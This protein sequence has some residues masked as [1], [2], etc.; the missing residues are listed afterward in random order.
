[1]SIQFPTD[2]DTLTNPA[3]TDKVATVSHSLQHSNA[4]DAIEA[5][6]AKVGKNNSGVTTSHD[7]KLST[8]TGSDK[9]AVQDGNQTLTNKTL[10]SPVLNTPKVGTSINDV[11]GNE[12][13]K[14]PATASAVN[15]I[16]VTNSVTGNDVSVDATGGD[17]NISLK[18][19]A[20]GTGK[21]KL[22]AVELQFPNVDGSNGELLKTDG[23]GVLS[24]V[25]ATTVPNAS[26]TVAG[27]TE[28]AT[29]AQVTAG[30]ATG[31]TGAKL[32]VTPAKLKTFT[33][34]QL[35]Q[36][37]SCAGTNG[38]LSQPPTTY[39]DIEAIIMTDN[40]KINLNIKGLFPQVRL[41]QYDFAS[42]NDITGAVIIGNYIYLLLENR[43]TTPDSYAVYRYD[44]TNI[45]AGGTLMTIAGAK[46][47]V[48][49]NGM[50][51]TSDGTYFY[52]NYEAGNSA[53][54]YVL[55]KYSLLGTTLTYVSSITCGSAGITEFCIKSD[56][57]IYA[58]LASDE[59]D[60]LKFNSSGTLLTTYDEIL[61][62][63]ARF[64]NIANTIYLGDPVL[65]DGIISK[66][67]L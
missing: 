5:L 51:M 33:D 13:I 55:A 26:E 65:H 66:T 61:S 56:G 19:K 30:T 43:S 14:T 12:V 9:V 44:K 57:T 22:G 60:L 41:T 16:T 25:G 7:Y 45:A 32:F 15:E 18:I 37:I 29:D 11:N 52:F 49:V 34:S 3:A 58:K 8:V 2:L 24:W 62:T 20:K 53:N 36:T 35:P 21:V 39:S 31:E 59:N 4:N 28:E 64:H 48:N 40:D 50:M 6:E 38:V 46:T 42:T 10:T 63:S 47:F 17:D 1:M 67:A 27:L 54:S 23:S